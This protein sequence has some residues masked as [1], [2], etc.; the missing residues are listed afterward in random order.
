M[1]IIRRLINTSRAARP[2]GP[3]NQAVVIGEAVYVSGCLGL[4]P[5]TNKLVPGGIVPEIRQALSN[6]KEILNEA[7]SD[8]A[9]VIK[10]TV[11]IT[12]ADD[13]PTVNEEYRRVFCAN[14]PAR[15]TI[16]ASLPLGARI[17]IDAI[18]VIGDIATE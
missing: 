2:A 1:P 8:V 6:I 5:N 4:D 18:A 15:T 13:S 7:N 11:Y 10:T 16:I 3:Y 12:T 14:F 9:N 17:E